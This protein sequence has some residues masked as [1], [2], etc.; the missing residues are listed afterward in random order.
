MST[1]VVALCTY[2]RSYLS[3]WLSILQHV[4]VTIFGASIIIGAV[5]GSGFAEETKHMSLKVLAYALSISVALSVVGFIWFS[6]KCNRDPLED[7]DEEEFQVA[8]VAKPY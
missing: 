4:F 3:F 2:L 1:G 6:F 7:N 5:I 8:R